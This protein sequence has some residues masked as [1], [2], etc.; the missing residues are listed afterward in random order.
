M[1]K[2]EKKITIT[3]RK[4]REKIRSHI[5]ITVGRKRGRETEEEEKEEGRTRK[6]VRLMQQQECRTSVEKQPRSHSYRLRATRRRPC[7]LIEG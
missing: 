7:R 6:S 2:E 4:P 3:E 1:I 5:G